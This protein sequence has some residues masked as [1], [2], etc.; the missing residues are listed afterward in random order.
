MARYKCFG[1]FRDQVGNTVVTQATGSGTATCSVVLTGTTTAAS[2]YTASSGGTAVNSVDCDAYGNFT[3]YVDTGDYGL[4]QGFD[5][6]LSKTGY[7]SQTYSNLTMATDMS[8]VQGSLTATHTLVQNQ[9]PITDDTY[10]LGEIGTPFKAFKA[11]VLH[12]TTDGKHY[13]IETINGTVT[14]TAL[15]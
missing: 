5:I 11:L 13:K 7:T 8:F 15:D 6:I 12:D 9:T 3:F 2:I 14:A 10:Y 1:T 4:S